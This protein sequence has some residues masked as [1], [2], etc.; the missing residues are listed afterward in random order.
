MGLF[1]PGEVIDN[2]DLQKRTRHYI[3][4][5][6]KYRYVAKLSL[7]PPE[8][9]FKNAVTSIDVQNKGLL[10][11]SETERYEVLS[12]RFLSGFGATSGLASDSDL[13]NMTEMG[14]VGQFELGKT[15]IDI[16]ETIKIPRART[17]VVKSRALARKRDNLVQWK[18]EGNSF[19]VNFYAI[20]LNYKGSQGVIGTI[21]S[22]K[23]KLYAFRDKMYHR[24]L[25]AL[26]Y[27]IVPIYNNMRVGKP[28]ETNI[29]ERKRDVSEEVLD[30]MLARKA[31]QE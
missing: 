28:L 5:G 24:E 11:L 17:R 27:L 23:Q 1:P 31:S 26:S 18:V 21:P 4:P 7:R 3:K 22:R 30:R 10:G 29:I 12:Q 8:A 13:K 9:F 16:D 2:I 25:G 19:D 14:L 6:R 20:V 15:G